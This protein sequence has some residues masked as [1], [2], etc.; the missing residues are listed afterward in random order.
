MASLALSSLRSVAP[1]PAQPPRERGRADGAQL[2]D[3]CGTALCVICAHRASAPRPG[4]SCPS[5]SS[6]F[7]GTGTG[8]GCWRKGLSPAADPPPHTLI[9]EGEG[10]KKITPLQ[11]S[12]CLLGGGMVSLPT[13]N[14]HMAEPGR[15]ENS[16]SPPAIQ[17][18]TEGQ[19]LAALDLCSRHLL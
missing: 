5:A 3:P 8:G 18:P 15:S 7:G 1:A 14:E 2:C 6:W 17:M 13:F 12:K 11:N 4:S 10:R 16:M 19:V 9:H